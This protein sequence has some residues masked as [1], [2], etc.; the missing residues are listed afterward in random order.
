MIICIANML[1]EVDELTFR[2]DSFQE[3]KVMNR[4]NFIKEAPEFGA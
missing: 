3:I 1:E 4:E 2:L